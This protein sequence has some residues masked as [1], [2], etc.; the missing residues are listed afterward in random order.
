MNNTRFVL[1][2]GKKTNKIFKVVHTKLM[3][4]QAV[5]AY[6][7]GGAL[8]KEERSP[9]WKLRGYKKVLGAS[10]KE[11]NFV[12]ETVVNKK[13]EEREKKKEASFQK[14]LPILFILFHSH[15]TASLLYSTPKDFHF[16]DAYFNS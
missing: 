12:R 4:Q 5:G 7:L 14:I 10:V 1:S 15:I 8:E 16:F 13:G 6:N 3:I 2:L 11:E 9:A